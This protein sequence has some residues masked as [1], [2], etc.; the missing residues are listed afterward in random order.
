MDYQ[1]FTEACFANVIGE[2]GLSDSDYAS[3]LGESEAS[4]DVLREAQKTGGLPL[5]K[6]PESCADFA[7]FAPEAERL[8]NQFDDVVILG[9]GGSSL[10]GQALIALADWGFARAWGQPRV[11]F[12]DNI[13]PHTFDRLLDELNA[14]RTA[15]VVIS[16]SGG[17]AETL[18]QFLACFDWVDRHVDQPGMH[19]VLVSQPGNS[20]LRRFADQWRLTVV[21]HDANIG[22]R[23]SVLTVVGMLP[24]LISGLDAHAVRAGAI[25]VLEQ[26]LTAQRPEDSPPAVGAAISIALYRTRGIV[27]TVMMPY[28]DR[29]S[30]FGLWFRQL[31]AESL[32]KDGQG[33]TP[34]N[35]LGTTDQHSQLQ[36]YLAGPPDKFYTL[37]TADCVGR[38]RSVPAALARDP[39]LAYLRGKTLGDLIDAEQRA[40]ADTLIRR[41]RPIRRIELAQVNERVM[42][43]LFM[44]FMLETMIA[45]H[46]LGVNAFDQP[47]VEEGKVLARAYLDGG[48]QGS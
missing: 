21:D 37:I 46:L 31:W 7:D 48:R 5:L 42:G 34:I 1:Q 41:S 3:V 26:T 30:V 14:A 8:R 39:D 9:T 13:D 38:G 15:F 6:L 45:A 47:A 10:G 23:Y 24:A 17:T 40:T 36:L 4:L 29:L 27:S 18:S 33:T 28:I 19:F 2:K 35:A 16:K 32:G 20:P 12:M 22:G 25:S 44:H 43:E 11:H